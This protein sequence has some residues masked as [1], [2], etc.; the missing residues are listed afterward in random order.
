MSVSP[1]LLPIATACIALAL[2]SNIPFSS[3]ILDPSH[4]PP[5]MPTALSPFAT[6][7]T[8]PVMSNVMSPYGSL[9]LE[10]MP[11]LKFLLVMMCSPPSPDTVSLDPYGT[12]IPSL[13]SVHSPVIVSA[14]SEFFPS[15]TVVSNAPRRL[16]FSKV[17][18][19]F[20]PS[21]VRMIMSM[22][23]SGSP[24]SLTLPPRILSIVYFL[25]ANSSRL[26]V[27]PAFTLYTRLSLSN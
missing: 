6:I 24:T 13:L 27:S 17:R 22:M 5:P 12:K 14:V 7:F 3:L 18:S 9:A 21:A 25:R 16:T 26:T 8:L 11:T 19:V 2:T 10:P 1:E 23:L 15:W 4:R 20:L